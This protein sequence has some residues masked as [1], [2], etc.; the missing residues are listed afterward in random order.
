MDGARWRK[1][2]VAATI[3]GAL[4]CGQ[5]TAAMAQ[6]EADT[7]GFGSF[8]LQGTHG[9][10]IVVLANSQPQFKHGEL[11]L[12]VYK[13]HAS[14][15]YLA[16][17]T[18][19]ATE[20]EADL[21]ALG[22]V[23]LQFEPGRERT[24]RSRCNPKRSLPLE[25]GAWVGRF[26]FRGEEGFTRATATRVPASLSPFFDT[27]CPTSGSGETWGAGVPGARLRVRA[28]H[29]RHA[30]SLQA[31]QNRPGA[32]LRL[33]ASL[34]EQRGRVFVERQVEEVYGGG[35]FEFD[36][37]LQVARLAP[38]RPFSGAAAFHRHAKPA[39]RWTGSLN[40]DFPGHS[41]VS[42]TGA[43]FEASLVH[44]LLTES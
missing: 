22:K 12:F 41:N 1:F 19:T 4:L 27:F 9:Y 18:V 7:G 36:P 8:R 23:S 39:N 43:R 33:S 29:G 28:G 17:A 13:P 42:L 44:A 37:D 30:L 31:N 26:E 16:D 11:L 3:V 25:H 10:S 14:A 20:I 6:G 32:P 38:P 24:V 21:G 2:G 40:V 35:G 5:A 15:I 34:S